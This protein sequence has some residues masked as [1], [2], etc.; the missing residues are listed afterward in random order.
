M[1]GGA[2]TG[3]AALALILA[4]YGALNHALRSDRIPDLLGR[5]RLPPEKGSDAVLL[6][7]AAAGAWLW[8]WS[9][10]PEGTTLR[11]FAFPL[12]ALLT[13]K[14]A[15]E[16]IDVASGDARVRSRLLALVSLAGLWTGPSFLVPSLFLLSR[17]FEGWLHHGTLPLRHLLGV[18]AFALL[19]APAGRLAGVEVGV[20]PYVFFALTLHTSHYFITGLAKGWLGPKWYSW[21]TDDRL[22]YIAASAY[23]WGWARFVPEKLYRKWLDVLRVLDRPFQAAAFGLEA[24]APLALL[25]PGATVGFAAGW[26]VFH[27]VVWLAS[28]ILFWEWIAA[29]LLLGWMVA[30]LPGAAVAGAFGWPQLGVA[31]ALMALLPFRQKLWKPKPLAWWD[32]P[33]TQRVR[34]RVEGESG[35]MYGLYNDFMCPHERLY[36]RVHGCFLIREPVFTYHL[37]EVF[38]RDLRDEIW[39]MEGTT[40]EVDRLREAYGIELHDPAMERQHVEFLRRFFRRLNQGARKHVLPRGL[41]WLKAPGGQM[42]YWGELP[43]YRRQEPVRAVEI[44]YREEFYDGEEFR[45]LREELLRRVE[46]DGEEPDAED[47]VREVTDGEVDAMIARRAI[48]R[49][50][51]IPSLD[52]GGRIWDP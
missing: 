7:L 39:E 27:L 38:K 10:V 32:T 23:S 37:G 40:G 21:V 11:L 35:E 34:W 36:G 3:L 4:G 6:L 12:A 2:W 33:L 47:G 5:L 1:E 49:L 17:R 41:R 42:F 48:G 18:A 13:W 14:A 8:P 26:A 50:I 29:N 19:A 25:A 20:A 16:D 43:P 44:L 22:H 15:T 28:G 52:D 9:S 30:S 31:V 46:I 45:F 24:L 51:E